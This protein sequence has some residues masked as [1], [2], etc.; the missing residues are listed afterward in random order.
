MMLCDFPLTAYFKPNP[1]ADPGRGRP[2]IMLIN[3]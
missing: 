3:V 1:V 2:L